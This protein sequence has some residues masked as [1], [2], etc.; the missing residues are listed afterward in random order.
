MVEYTDRAS[1]KEAGA[2]R[3]N[4]GIPCIHGHL[5][6]RYVSGGACVEC[7][8]NHTK[9]RDV[10][11]PSYNRERF[12]AW[13]EKNRERHCHN[14]KQWKSQNLEKFK[15]YRKA[16]YHRNKVALREQTKLW[17]KR[18]PQRAFLQQKRWIE[19]NRGRVNAYVARRRALKVR[20]TPVWSDQVAIDHFYSECPLGYEV[21]HIVPLVSEEVCGLH[22]LNNLQ[23]LPVKENRSKGNRL[24]AKYIY[25]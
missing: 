4:T 17:R 1:A 19:L 18:N 23:Y 9:A 25:P 11:L 7:M 21:D 16:Y 5:A 2:K 22:V 8:R 3:Y 14:T 12:A 24:I 6:D 15:G 10:R 13:Y 20:A